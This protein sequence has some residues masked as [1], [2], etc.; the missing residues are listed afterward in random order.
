MALAL[1]LA[2]SCFFFDGKVGRIA[3]SADF[4]EGLCVCFALVGVA[5]QTRRDRFPLAAAHLQYNTKSGVAIPPAL[6]AG[7]SGLSHILLMM[8]LMM[9]FL[10][11]LKTARPIARRQSYSMP[12]FAA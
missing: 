3:G 5:D 11:R 12:V 8:M 10:V 6:A 4:L 2:I 9:I 1:A 7:S